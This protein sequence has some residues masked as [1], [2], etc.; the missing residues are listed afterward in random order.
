MRQSRPKEVGKKKKKQKT[1]NPTGRRKPNPTRPLPRGKKRRE[2]HIYRVC[3]IRKKDGGEEK[4][5]P[6]NLLKRKFVKKGKVLGKNFI[7]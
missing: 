1:Q 2:A 4:E 6:P 3:R 5:E 7:S